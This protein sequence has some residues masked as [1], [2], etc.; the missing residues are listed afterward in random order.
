MAPCVG[1]VCPAISDCGIAAGAVTA[2]PYL[3]L[4]LLIN[5]SM[6]WATASGLSSSADSLVGVRDGV[7]G[8][9]SRGVE[10]KGGR[11]VEGEGG[12]DVEGKGGRGV[13]GKGGKGVRVG[14]G[15]PV[16]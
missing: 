15:A 16:P 12:R 8:E 2:K 9:G 3:S 7:G 4:N 10:G 13:E 5:G 11:G 1:C 14:V 6:R